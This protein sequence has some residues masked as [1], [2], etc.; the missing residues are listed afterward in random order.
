MAIISA[1]LALTTLYWWRDV[2]GHVT[3]VQTQQ[4]GGISPARSPNIQG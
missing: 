4:S 2:R 3:A 1:S